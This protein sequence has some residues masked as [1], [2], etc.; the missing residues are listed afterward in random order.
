MQ[1]PAK[2]DHILTS[3]ATTVLHCLR[4]LQQSHVINRNKGL[5][6]RQEQQTIHTKMKIAGRHRFSITFAFFHMQQFRKC[7][8]NIAQDIVATN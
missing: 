7:D 2:I 6:R 1:K 8:M 4:Q 3:A 5:H